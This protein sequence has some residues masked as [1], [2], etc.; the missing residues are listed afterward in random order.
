[1]TTPCESDVMERGML[2]IPVSDTP[3]ARTELFVNEEKGPI[4]SAK[5][6]PKFD[7]EARLF[8]RE[9]AVPCTRAPVCVVTV[10]IVAQKAKHDALVTATVPLKKAAASATVINCVGAVFEPGR[11]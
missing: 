9:K 8:V 10:T 7:I 6:P 5:P 1:M 11:N 3:S 2:W 4:V